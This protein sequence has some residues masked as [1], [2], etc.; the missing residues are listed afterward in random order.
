V[1]SIDVEEWYHSCW[2]PE[3]V[4]PGRRPALVEELD[5]LLPELAA[6]LDRLGCRAT[7][8][9]LGEVARRLP[10]RIRELARAGHEVACHGNLHLRA[11]ERPLAEFRRDVSIAR[12]LLQQ[13]LGAPVFGFRAPEWSLRRVGGARLRAIAELGFAYDSSLT[14]AWGAGSREN[15]RG[16]TRIRWPD[17]GTLL[18]LPPLTWAGG[19]LP[20]SGWTGRAL[21]PAF[22]ARAIRRAQKRG[23]PALLVAHPWELVDRPCPGLMTGFARF[24]HEVGRRGYGE[25][26]EALLRS[27]PPSR[28]LVDLIAE[29]GTERPEEAPAAQ[30]LDADDTLVAESA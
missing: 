7:F 17:R 16:A 4:D 5:A 14:P 9:V 2:I 6:R 3:Y 10:T 11:S 20:G 26:F 25:R 24:F 18:E 8:F 21:A 27:L 19:R 23:E 29:A 15:P 12:D 28:P 22:V 1:L 13:I 30:P